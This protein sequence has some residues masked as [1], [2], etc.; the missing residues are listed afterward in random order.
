MAK[1]RK[2]RVEFRKNRSTRRRDGDLTRSLGADPDATVDRATSERISGKGELTGKR[3]VVAPEDGAGTD[4]LPVAAGESAWRG[5][6][7]MTIT[8]GEC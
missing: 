8:D 3:T 6:V 4:G 5:R 7:L 1:P 2:Q